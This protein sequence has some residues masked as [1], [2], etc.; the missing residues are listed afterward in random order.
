MQKVVRLKTLFQISYDNMELNISAIFKTG[1]AFDTHLRYR[2]YVSENARQ[3]NLIKAMYGLLDSYRNILKTNGEKST[4][5]ITTRC[6]KGD[7]G[8]RGKYGPKG[9]KGSRGDPGL[10]GAQGPEGLEGLK[11]QKGDPGPRGPPG[12][13]IEEPKI[14]V[15]PVNTTV[16]EGDTATFTCESKGYPK[17]EI[18]WM[19]GNMSVGTGNKRFKVIE[20][21]GLQ[22]N[23]VE[24]KDEGKVKCTAK[25]VFG[26]DEAEATLIVQGKN[27]YFD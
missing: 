27:T 11:G 20:N 8:R 12:L 24:S 17:P 2:R 22:V 16:K 10:P 23:S 4:C 6:Q 3:R 5:D 19:V 7:R 26:T 13:S 18:K 15:K 1:I 14:T 9:E 25:N 21:I